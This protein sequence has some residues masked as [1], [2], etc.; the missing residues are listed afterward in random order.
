[1]SGWGNILGFMGLALGA[2][3][4]VGSFSA[5][6]DRSDALDRMAD[7]RNKANE[8]ERRK[9]T[10]SLRR[11]RLQ[12][13]REARIKGAKQVSRAVA[14]GAFG[15]SQTIGQ[16]S[17]RG[18]LG[19]TQSQ[20][21]GNFLFQNQFTS[22]TSQQNE[23]LRQSSIFGTQARQAGERNAMYGSFASFGGSIFKNREDIGSIF[24]R[25]S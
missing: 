16:S 2:V 22:F 18:A 12:T 3:G 21:G 13:I 6:E 11:Q 24:P 9:Q 10:L 14:Q 19:S 5:S 17:F 15:G 20:A 4:L 8:I 23:F 25:I 7:A 1:M